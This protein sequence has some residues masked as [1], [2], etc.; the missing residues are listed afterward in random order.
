MTAD[1]QVRMLARGQLVARQREMGDHRM[2]QV[3]QVLETSQDAVNSI[4]RLYYAVRAWEMAT[5]DLDAPKG[6]VQH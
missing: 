3:L 6:A 2:M 1:R 5:F 4:D